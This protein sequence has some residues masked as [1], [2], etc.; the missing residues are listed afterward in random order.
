MCMLFHFLFTTTPW[1]RCYYCPHF[2][3]ETEAQGHLVTF[4]GSS[5]SNLKSWD[6]NPGLPES[7]ALMSLLCLRGK[8]YPT[9]V[10]TIL[11]GA[12]WERAASTLPLITFAI[13]FL[14]LGLSFLTWKPG[15]PQLFSWLLPSWSI[16]MLRDPSC[17]MWLVWS[18][19]ASSALSPLE[20]SALER[21]GQ[22]VE[23]RCS[24]CTQLSLA[25]GQAVRLLVRR[26]RAQGSVSTRVFFTRL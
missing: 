1:C 5:D 3:D 14:F 8:F 22:E 9:K 15:M 18:A 17:D 24:G 25:D 4:P 16:T 21:E 23:I 10:D 6:A 20:L 19:N 2:A 13:Y 12:C 7:E 26:A 11:A